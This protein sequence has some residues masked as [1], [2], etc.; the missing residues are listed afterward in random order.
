M[1]RSLT[2]GILGPLRIERGRA[3]L[4]PSGPRQQAVL[5]AL[6][7]RANEVVS[8]DTLIEA[9]WGE[10]PPPTA[11]TALQV[12]VSKLRRLLEG[13]P[14]VEIETVPPGYRIR[15]DAEAV[16]ALRF[17]ALVQDGTH[18]LAEGDSGRAADVLA[19]ALALWRGRPLE[20]VD[21]PGIPPF[22]L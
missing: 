13:D 22:Q 10:D 17:R 6:L 2:F 9:V 5:A 16:D 1:A 11:R 18:A 8:T 7:L 4:S 20:G 12:H 3:V 14:R 21:A 15:V 19:R